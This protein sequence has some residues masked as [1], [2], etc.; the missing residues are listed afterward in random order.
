MLCVAFNY[1]FA[2]ANQKE[3]IRIP[4]GTP[5]ER[6]NQT[7]KNHLQKA[8]VRVPTSNTHVTRKY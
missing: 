4:A 7:S 6:F 1:L 5:N 3:L 2:S 8:L